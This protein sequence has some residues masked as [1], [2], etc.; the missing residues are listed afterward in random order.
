MIFCPLHNHSEFSA[1]DGLSTCREIAE[2]AVELGCPCC[3]I[4]DHGTVAG[5]L[6]FAKELAKRDVKPIFGAE[7]YHGVQPKG[8]KNWTRNERDQSHFVVGATSNEGLRNL[9]RLNDLASKNFR[10][11]GRVNWEDLEGFSEGLFATSACIQGLVP[12]GVLQGDLTA[13]DKYLEIYKDK[14]FIELHTYPGYE[15]EQLNLALAQV[16][17]ERG[18]PVVYANDAHFAFPRQYATHDV[19]VAMQTGDSIDTSIQDRKMWH[20]MAL[21]MMDEVEIR[22]ALHYLPS[23]V[24]D[25]AL[26]NTVEI[27]E[28]CDV[29]LPE[30]RRHLP[31]FIPEHSPFVEEEHKGD[32]AAKLFID[33]VERGIHLRY[34]DPS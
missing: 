15:H 24:V 31:V 6:E 13:L 10:Y 1:L 5:H 16:A 23:S 30:V 3:G 14:F 4:T 34:A 29:Q 25:E 12:Q 21:Y 28:M 9:W 11:V 7:L 8:Y 26:R 32:S 2:R 22:D 27:G 20:P 19:Y 18:I 33:L 17:Q